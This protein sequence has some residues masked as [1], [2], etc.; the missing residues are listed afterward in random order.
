M[1]QR[2]RLDW[3]CTRFTL[4]ECPG[5]GIVVG[6]VD[7]PTSRAPLSGSVGVVMVGVHRGR[8]I[9]WSCVVIAVVAVRARVGGAP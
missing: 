8:A 6:I 4:V 7:G 2:R 5:G 1:W 9:A 3:G